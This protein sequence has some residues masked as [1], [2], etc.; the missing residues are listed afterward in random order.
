MMLESSESRQISEAGYG[1]NVGWRSIYVSLFCITNLLLGCNKSV[2][3][4]PASYDTI[5]SPKF[6]LCV[7]YRNIGAPE[8]E[9]KIVSYDNSKRYKSLRE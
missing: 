6:V 7:A 1:L 9:R 5:F 3:K 4:F 2:W 8:I